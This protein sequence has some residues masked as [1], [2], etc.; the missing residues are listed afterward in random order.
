MA[1]KTEHQAN[2]G[3]KRKRDHFDYK[4]FF[5]QLIKVTSFEYDLLNELSFVMQFICCMLLS[6][7]S[8]FSMLRGLLGGLLM[9]LLE[10]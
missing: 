5:F 1:F 7:L 2:L 3:R 8:M 10:D 4:L 9:F 6:S